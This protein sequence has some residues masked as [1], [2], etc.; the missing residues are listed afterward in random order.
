VDWTQFTFVAGTVAAMLIKQ[1]WMRD[2]TTKRDKLLPI[3]A[4]AANLL[5]RI[6]TELKS[7]ADEV[8]TLESVSVSTVVFASFWDGGIGSAIKLVGFG[9]YD[10]LLSWGVHRAKRY[11]DAWRASKP[12]PIR[13]KK[14]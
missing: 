7:G 1:F 9:A 13:R 12:T 11:R 5:T 3:I 14:R 6:G 10:T 8:F 2:D 4:F